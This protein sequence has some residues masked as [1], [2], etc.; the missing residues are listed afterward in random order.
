MAGV[1]PARVTKIR[2]SQIFI[3]ITKVSFIE[4]FTLTL[5]LTK[6]AVLPVYRILQAIGKAALQVPVSFSVSSSMA[7]C[8]P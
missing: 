5:I 6:N 7:I 1:L 8:H 4:K 3:Q 2:L